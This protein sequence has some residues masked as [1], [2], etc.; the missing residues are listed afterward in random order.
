MSISYETLVPWGRSFEEYRA[1]FDL[2]D[3]DLDRRILGCG[4]DPAAFNGELTKR[5]GSVVS[6]DPIYR[7][8]PEEIGA[9]IEATCDEVLE[10]TARN[11]E[12]FRWDSIASPE[13]LG[14]I[15]KEAMNDFLAD[16]ELGKG[17]GRYLCG[18]LPHLPVLEG[19]F[20]LALSS[21]F[22]FLYSENLSCEFH[23][24]A[25][26]AILT[27][28][29]ELRIFP[30]LDLNGS[31]SPYADRIGEDFRARGFSVEERVVD[32]EFQIGGNRMLRICS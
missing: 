5:G 18:E 14:R 6:V 4:D 10:K 1:M 17:E 26:T 32:Y 22:L 9:R 12:L 7:F 15:R 21:H 25:I 29:D 31:R 2:S 30:L 24:E 20:D 13:E 3:K 19:K 23:E 16:F 28:A 27:V 8:S 11:R